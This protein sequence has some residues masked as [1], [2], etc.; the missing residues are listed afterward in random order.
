[1]LLQAWA[2]GKEAVQKRAP[3]NVERLIVKDKD[4]KGREILT[5]PVIEKFHYRQT[6]RLFRPMDDPGQICIVVI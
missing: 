3:Q 2:E 4:R 1:M 5:R 6:L